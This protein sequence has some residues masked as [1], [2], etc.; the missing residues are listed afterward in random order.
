MQLQ[1]FLQSNA[2]TI[3]LAVMAGILPELPVAGVLIFQSGSMMKYL[4]T[5]SE[6]KS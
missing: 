4:I 5:S 6:K 2:I 1:L 3:A